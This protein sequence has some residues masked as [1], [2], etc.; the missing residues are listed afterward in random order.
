MSLPLIKRSITTYK[1]FRVP[2]PL[3]TRKWGS[4]E[5]EEWVNAKIKHDIPLSYS[6][7]SSGLH[8]W[9][10][11]MQLV[12]WQQHVICRRWWSPSIYIWRKRWSGPFHGSAF[13]LPRQE[14]SVVDSRGFV[15]RLSVSEGPHVTTPITTLL[16]AVP[17][18]SNLQV[19]FQQTHRTCFNNSGGDLMCCS[20]VGV[21]SKETG[22]F[23]GSISVFNVG[24]N[25]REQ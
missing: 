6:A 3:S 15:S 1:L 9:N 17:L 25:T 8:A 18:P 4:F 22:N 10:D 19:E 12:P 23:I 5:S 7:S 14:F 20:C 11:C 16:W 24:Y 21:D 13:H 2:L